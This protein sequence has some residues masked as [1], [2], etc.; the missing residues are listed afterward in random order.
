MQH[1]QNLI[2]KELLLFKKQIRFDTQLLNIK[3]QFKKSEEKE[4]YVLMEATRSVKNNAHAKLMN[5]KEEYERATKVAAEIAISR[6]DLERN[7]WLRDKVSIS[8][9]FD[10]QLRNL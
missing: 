10:L 8:E 7:K 2:S 5:Q 1:R 6:F 3:E 4:R 9:S